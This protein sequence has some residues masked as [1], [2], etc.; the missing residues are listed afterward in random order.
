MK[1]CRK[2]LHRLL[3]SLA[4][5]ASLSHFSIGAIAAPGAAMLEGAIDRFMRTQTTG[6]PGT[7]SYSIGSIDAR[8]SLPPCAQPE[9]FLPAG[10][11]LWGKGHVGVR[12]ATPSSWTIYVP[13][14]VQ[15]HGSYLTAARPLPPGHV[16]TNEDIGT[17]S[18]DLAGLPAGIARE[19]SQVI[20]RNTSAPLAAGQPL[21]LDLVR[22]PV[23]V[24]Q[25]QGVRLVARGRGFEVSAEGR[26][27]AQ[28][29]LGQV[30]QVRVASGQ[31]VHG[32]ARHDA[33]VEVS[34]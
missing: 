23:V 25:G 15:V 33:V 4:A 20:G 13:V 18:G 19:P 24:Q 21:R 14:T 27:L 17:A 2:L 6:L 3:A 9:V 1:I 34:H 5:A 31:T 28:A 22:A 26:A 8:S 29:Q 11:R 7:V 10:A 16:I 32:I 12:C 30:V